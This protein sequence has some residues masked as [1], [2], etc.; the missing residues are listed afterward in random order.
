VQFDVPEATSEVRGGK[1]DVDYVRHDIK[2]K[3]G[4]SQSFL[5]L[6]FGTYAM[7]DEYGAR[8][9]STG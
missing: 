8:R 9:R 1:P 2:R 5:E 6:W 7:N 4:K 3:G